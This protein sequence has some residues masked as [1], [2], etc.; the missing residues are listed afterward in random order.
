ML[1]WRRSR[2]RSQ[3]SLL[4]ARHDDEGK[5]TFNQGRYHVNEMRDDVWNIQT[6]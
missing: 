1:R 3:S 6:S 5:I 2:T 4:A